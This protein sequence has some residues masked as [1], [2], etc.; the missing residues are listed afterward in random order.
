MSDFSIA[1]PAVELMIEPTYTAKGIRIE[2]EQVIGK[3]K[4]PIRAAEWMRGAAMGIEE[5]CPEIA[6]ALVVEGGRLEEGIRA[7]LEHDFDAD[8]ADGLIATVKEFY[9]QVEIWT[10]ID[11]DGDDV[12]IYMR[13]NCPKARELLDCSKRT[14]AI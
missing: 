3:I 7:S 2:I 1:A 6:C 4:M 5:T 11:I 12:G 10:D 8:I 13:Q 14:A 9:P